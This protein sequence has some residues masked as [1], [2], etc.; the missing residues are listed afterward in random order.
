MLFPAKK[1]FSKK[2]FHFLCENN[3]YGAVLENAN[4][5]GIWF[6]G[7]NLRNTYLVGVK[8]KNA[9]LESTD[10]RVVIKKYLFGRSLHS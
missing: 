8:L 5:E 6:Y 9:G 7:A 1:S 10:L 3:Y 4:L 2:L